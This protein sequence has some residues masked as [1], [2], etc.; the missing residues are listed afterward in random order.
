VALEDACDAANA[1]IAELLTG[2][3]GATKSFA[4][5]LKKIDEAEEELKKEWAETKKEA[6]E[7]LTQVADGHKDL[8]EESADTRTAM[9][10]LKKVVLDG[11]EEFDTEVE[12]QRKGLDEF[13]EQ[14]VHGSESPFEQLAKTVSDAASSLE[15]AVDTITQ[16]VSQLASETV[17]FFEGEIENALTENERQVTERH[18]QL[19]DWINTTLK[20]DMETKHGEFKGKMTELEGNTQT[21]FEE[22]HQSSESESKSV[23]EQ[24]LG[25][26]MN[27]IQ[28]IMSLGQTLS[29]TLTFLA[30]SVKTTGETIGTAKQTVETCVET[31]NVTIESI[32]DC[33]ESFQKICE[34]FSFL[35]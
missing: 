32:M 23:L 13:G 19:E 22:T 18:S 9:K 24:C 35:G 11:K 17:S 8:V 34:G 25:E 10:D 29:S 30:D 1:E 14:D 31:S 12:A 6:E 33:F 28:Q 27:T 3:A 7:F 2:W 20:P 5:A 21:K 26:H 16:A 4:E 15:K